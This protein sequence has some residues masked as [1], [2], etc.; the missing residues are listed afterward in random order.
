M[1][2]TSA[3]PTWDP[4]VLRGLME[5]AIPFNRFLGL[6]VLKME[7]AEVRLL[8]PFRDDFVGDPLRRALHGGTISMLIDTAGGAAAFLN[9]EADERVSTVD[10]VV[11][12]LR[13][14][15]CVDIVA[16]ARVVR[17]GNRVVTANVEVVRADG[18]GG[19]IAQGRGVYNIHRPERGGT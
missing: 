7:R 2:T 15:P 10:L 13:P 3:P 18:D 19:V 1:T 9:V 12:Y 5:D 16:I 14:G 17:R 8:L 6:K 11:D 4:D